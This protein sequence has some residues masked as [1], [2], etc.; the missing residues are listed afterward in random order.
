MKYS[1]NR[2]LW[3]FSK[4]TPVPPSA[5]K[6]IRDIYSAVIAAE[7][8]HWSETAVGGSVLVVAQPPLEPAR[9]VC[10]PY[11]APLTVATGNVAGWIAEQRRAIQYIEDV[12]AAYGAGTFI[13]RP[14][15]LPAPRHSFDAEREIRWIAAAATGGHF[16]IYGVHF[17]RNFDSNWAV[18]KEVAS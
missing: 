10:Q 8:E 17:T 1:P 7:P 6:Y 14:T 18:A 15:P 11:G 12:L 4:A 5:H 9:P 2:Y 3:R 16:W 13:V